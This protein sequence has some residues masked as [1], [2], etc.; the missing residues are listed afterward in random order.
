MDE[1][2]ARGSGIALA[3]S[4]QHLGRVLSIQRE[5]AGQIARRKGLPFLVEE[6]EALHHLR[7]WRGEQLLGGVVPA[8]MGARLVRV[9]QLTSRRLHG[10][11]V[12][13][14]V[15]HEPEVLAKRECA[16]R[17]KVRFDRH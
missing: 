9:D 10:D 2:P 13:E 17:S 1:R 3:D 5:P 8:Q 15:E 6:L 11:A 16:T 7:K 14:P 12:T 4:D